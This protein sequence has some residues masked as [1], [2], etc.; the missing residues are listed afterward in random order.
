MNRLSTM[1]CNDFLLLHERLIEM[2]AHHTLL[3]AEV[4]KEERSLFSYVRP[5]VECICF[6]YA[7]CERRKL[8][9]S[10]KTNE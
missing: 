1:I 10:K 3:P 8:P 6:D 7:L 4:E 5:W 2:I 9:I